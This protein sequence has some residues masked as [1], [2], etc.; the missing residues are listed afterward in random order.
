MSNKS[1]RISCKS[2]IRS[3]FLTASY[4]KHFYSCV[5]ISELMLD[6]KHLLLLSQRHSVVPCES[7]GMVVNPGGAETVDCTTLEQE[8]RTRTGGHRKV[9]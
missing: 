9:P 8:H 1:W 5:C 2:R 7:L 3:P 4:D 6:H